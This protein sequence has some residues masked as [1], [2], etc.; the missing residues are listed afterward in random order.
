MFACQLIIISLN[1]R[2]LRMPGFLSVHSLQVV[3][4]KLLST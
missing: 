4:I 2:V 1:L 3:D